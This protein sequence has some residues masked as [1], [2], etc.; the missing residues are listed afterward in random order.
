MAVEGSS[1]SDS[2]VEVKCFM[3]KQLCRS[4]HTAARRFRQRGGGEFLLCFQFDL[5]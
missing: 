4:R 2:G 5:F 3:C 1:V